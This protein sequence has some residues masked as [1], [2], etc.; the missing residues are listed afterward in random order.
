MSGP[1]D[2]GDRPRLILAI[3]TPR[4]GTTAL[5]DSL[6]TDP[7][8]RAFHEPDDTPER[9]RTDDPVYFAERL[10]PEAEIGALIRAGAGPVLLRPMEEL[11]D[12]TLDDVAEEYAAYDLRVVWIYRSAADTIASAIAK[13]WY[14]PTED[15]IE[16]AVAEWNRRNRSVLDARRIV[17]TIV[18]YED[19]AA[20]PALVH[21]VGRALGL[22]VRSAFTDTGK[23]RVELPAHVVERIR[24]ATA[25]VEAGLDARRL[26]VAPGGDVDEQPGL[27]RAHERVV[28]VTDR[29]FGRPDVVPAE[30]TGLP[31]LVLWHR[32]S[33]GPVGE[34][35]TAGQEDLSWIG[36]APFTAVLVLRLPDVPTLEW[37]PVLGCG[38]A[39]QGD[40]GWVVVWTSPRSDLRPSLAS[41]TPSPTASVLATGLTSATGRPPLSILDTFAAAVAVPAG[42]GEETP[43]VVGIRYETDPDPALTLVAAGTAVTTFGP[44]PTGPSRP[45]RRL[46]VGGSDGNPPFEG[47][48]IEVALFARA[49]EEPELRA[50][51]AG[52]A[53]RARGGP[54]VP[55]AGG[56]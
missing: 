12:R 18:R 44:G 45:D 8:V 46:W 38:R 13:G 47:E 32:P 31:G 40:R 30:P 52:A 22:A 20:H 2:E 43:L 1:S 4:S 29:W 42:V 9:R 26:T 11:A 6:A 54:A 19:V 10:R 53:E 3:G 23:R 7:S 24:A 5:F 35:A 27:A 17:P 25:E 49:L 15:A 14:P 37:G 21:R 41:A 39:L 50:V 55:G 16:A 51:L 34:M 48:I 36:V 56:G 28:D 33:D